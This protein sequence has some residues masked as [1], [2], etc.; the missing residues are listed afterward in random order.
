MIYGFQTQDEAAATAAL[1]VYGVYRSRD[2][3]RFKVTPDMWGRIDRAVK[4]AAKRSRDLPEFIEQ[5]K[6]KLQCATLHPRWMTTGD[7]ETVTM[8][9][10]PITGELIG[11]GDANR[12]EF[13]VNIIDGAEAKPVLAAL[14]RK[15]AYVIA[16]VRDRLERERPLEA[17]T[18][19]ATINHEED[20]NDD[21]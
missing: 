20:A 1:L 18:E 12:R 17:L 9:M 3:R 16:L 15:T 5:L 21:E 14:K 13:W 8:V 10:D 6:P 4:S 2:V 7:I 19:Q 11:R